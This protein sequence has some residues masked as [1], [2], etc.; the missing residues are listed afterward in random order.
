MYRHR[1]ETVVTRDLPHHHHHHHDDDKDKKKSVSVIAP[2]W[3]FLVSG[4]TVYALLGLHILVDNDN[5]RHI[6]HSIVSPHTTT[7]SNYSLL[8]VFVLHISCSNLWSIPGY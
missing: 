2:M 8:K 1:N 7:C 6:L 4:P 3:L 5:T